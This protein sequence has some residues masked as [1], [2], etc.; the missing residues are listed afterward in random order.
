MLPRKFPCRPIEFDWSATN[1]DPFWKNPLQEVRFQDL[2]SWKNGRNGAIALKVAD[3]KF[4]RFK[5]ADNKLAGMEFELANNGQYDDRVEVLDS[6]VIG[7]SKGN[8]DSSLS[9]HGIISPRTEWFTIRNVRFHNFNQ[10]NAAALGDCS[11][12][13]HPAATDSGARTVRTEKLSFTNVNKKI[14]YQYPFKGIYEDLDGTLTG[15]GPNTFA[16]AYFPHNIQPECTYDKAVFDGITCNNQVQIRRIAF[17]GATPGAMFKGMPIMV[18][19]F[20]DVITKAK[21]NLTTYIN[22]KSLYSQVNFKEKTDPSNGW[23][24]PFVTG[25]KYR[26]SIGLTGLN[27]ENLKIELSD[28]WN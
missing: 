8:A 4:E 21:A 1:G 20:D 24:A 22:T 15:L 2:T 19:Q 26:W 7:F 11:H 5:T 17:H 25:H 13:F 18:L 9:P 16:S 10:N 23:A 6:L 14:R 3:V 28:R 27:F 12:C